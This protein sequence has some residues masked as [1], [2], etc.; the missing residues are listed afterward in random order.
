[1]HRAFLMFVGALLGWKFICWATEEKETENHEEQKHGCTT[2]AGGD[3][4]VRSDNV[5]A[6]HHNEA[7]DSH[8]PALR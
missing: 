1:M 2:V 6:Q 8:S 7:T 3:A 5:G 4:G